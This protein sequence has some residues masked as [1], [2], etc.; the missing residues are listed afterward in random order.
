MFDTLIGNCVKSYQNEERREPKI[1]SKLRWD[2]FAL[3]PNTLQHLTVSALIRGWQEDVYVH[4]NPAMAINLV[5]TSWQVISKSCSIIH[6]EK[7]EGLLFDKEIRSRTIL[8]GMNRVM[9]GERGSKKEFPVSDSGGTK[10][11]ETWRREK[12]SWIWLKTFHP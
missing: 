8:K 11:S 5:I 12:T 4:S 6:T 9:N 7:R 3:I 2:P 1:G 10:V